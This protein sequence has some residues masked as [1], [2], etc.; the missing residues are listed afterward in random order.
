M[1]IEVSQEASLASTKN[2]GTNHIGLVSEI[3]H[4]MGGMENEQRG[5]NDGE[6]QLTKEDF[7]PFDDEEEGEGEG[8]G[9]EDNDDE[10]GPDSDLEL[11]M[12]ND[13]FIGED[14]DDDDEGDGD[15][16]EDNFSASF[17]SLSSSSL[18]AVSV[19]HPPPSDQ[20]YF[21]SFNVPKSAAAASPK[22]QHKV[23]VRLYSLVY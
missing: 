20:N 4:M 17:G 5:D 22:G 14:D 23:R 1:V 18:P 3:E 15:E 7:F 9:D 21:P 8:E 19:T 10:N 13:S 12:S 16:D 6:F 2:K 11:S